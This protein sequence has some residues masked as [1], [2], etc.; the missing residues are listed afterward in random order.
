MKEEKWQVDVMNFIYEEMFYCIHNKKTL[1]YA[2][3]VMML[4]I[5]RARVTLPEGTTEQTLGYIQKK[6]TST[7]HLRRPAPYPGPRSGPRTRGPTPRADPVA[8]LHELTLL[9]LLLVE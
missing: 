7:Q 1:P 3:Y 4:L 5:S 8:L 9:L 2:P 6:P